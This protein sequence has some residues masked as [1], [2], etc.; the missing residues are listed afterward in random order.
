M[1]VRDGATESGALEDLRA[2]VG[3]QIADEALLTDLAGGLGAVENVLHEVVRSDVAEV[4]EAA[5]HLVEAG[6]KRFRPLFTLLAGQFG[7]GG[8]DAV[9]TAAAAVELVHLATLYHDDVMDEATMRRGAESVNARWDNTVAILTGD[10]LFAHASRL[11][12]DL[13]TDAARIIAETFGELVTGQMRETVGPA[14]GEDPIE[15]YLTVIGQKTGSLIATSGRFGGMLSGAPDEYIEALRR[16]GDIIG[17]AFQISDDII[18]I[19]SP[20]AELG[21]SQG[22]DLREGVKTLPMLYELSEDKPDPRLSELLSGPISGD[23]EVSEALE[24]LRSSRG[25]A[26]ARA[27][28]SG[29]A[30]RA[31]TELAAL[32]PS[33]AR[34]AC[35]SVADYL[36]ARTH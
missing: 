22:T 27:T 26:R 3:L 16:F 12:A 2:S 24:L 34:D 11:V 1:S 25:L 4:H 7:T 13:G 20:S 33:P 28:L 31:R 5:R 8:R 21:K 15:H 23:A 29:Y 6:G 10:F 18:D 17:T 9:V 30:Q 19:D 36:V 35:E 14:E 32:P